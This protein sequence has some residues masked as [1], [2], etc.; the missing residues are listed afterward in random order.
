MKQKFFWVP[1]PKTMEDEQREYDQAVEARR[2]RIVDDHE[3]CGCLF[4]M[5]VTDTRFAQQLKDG[6][7]DWIDSRMGLV[8]YEALSCEVRCSF[9]SADEALLFKLTFGGQ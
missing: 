4:G 2:Q 5:W 3:G 9:R 8:S 7:R 6:I 1:N